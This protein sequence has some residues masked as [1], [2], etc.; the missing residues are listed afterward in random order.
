MDERRRR[1]TKEELEED[2]FLEW[3]LRAINYVKQRAQLFIGG[4]VAVVALIL[5]AGFVQGQSEDPKRRVELHLVRA[6]AH[7]KLGE[8]EEA[9]AILVQHA[10]FESELARSIRDEVSA[11]REAGTQPVG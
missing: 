3:V 10:Q 8:H 1:P 2:E 6:L 11:T 7:A 9:A 5:I 4:A